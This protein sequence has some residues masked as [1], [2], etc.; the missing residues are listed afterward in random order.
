MAWTGSICDQPAA[1]RAARSCYYGDTNLAMGDSDVSTVAVAEAAA[2][3]NANAGYV[4]ERFGGINTARGFRVA[5]NLG[6]TF[7]STMVA[8]LASL[9]SN[10]NGN[11]AMMINGA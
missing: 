8:L 11:K 2:V 4:G 5:S 6:A 7:G 9:P 10:P 3:A 1:Y